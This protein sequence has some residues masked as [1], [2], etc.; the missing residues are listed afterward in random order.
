MRSIPALRGRRARALADPEPTF[1]LPN[2]T[3]QSGRPPCRVAS[4]GLLQGLGP[5]PRMPISAAISFFKA[6]DPVDQPVRPPDNLV[7]ELDDYEVDSDEFR[8]SSS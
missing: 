8:R 7:V 1:E 4:L 2:R 5:L 6:L 3:L